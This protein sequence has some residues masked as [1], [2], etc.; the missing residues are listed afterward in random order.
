LLKLARWVSGR[1]TRLSQKPGKRTPNLM[2]QKQ[3][4]Q[5]VTELRLWTRLHE[6]LACI[7][8]EIENTTD[9]LRDLLILVKLIRHDDEMWAALLGLSNEHAGTDPKLASLVIG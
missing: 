3:E 9:L 8:G 5:P 2:S 6:I 7:S 1:V 4:T